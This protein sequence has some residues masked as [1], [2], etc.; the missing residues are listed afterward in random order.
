MATAYEV[1][2]IFNVE[3]NAVSVLNELADLADELVTV[4]GE[5]R[6]AFLALNSINLDPAIASITAL[7][8][9][10]TDTAS[11]LTTLGFMADGEFGNITTAVDATTASVDRLAAS[12][13]AVKGSMAGGAGGRGGAA[14]T[15][16]LGGAVGGLA[17][18]VPP[19][20]LAAAGTYEALHQNWNENLAIRQ[21]LINEGIDPDS[22]Q[23]VAAA[24]SLRT[25][26]QS[27]ATGTIISAEQTSELYKTAA[28]VLGF[29]GPQGLAELSN[30]MPTIVRAA[31]NAVQQ[32]GGS[33]P[34]IVKAD[35]ELAHQLHVYD[36]ERLA[37]VLSRIG[38][39][40]SSTGATLPEELNIL[41]YALPTVGALGGSAQEAIADVGFLQTQMGSTTTAGTSFNR[42]LVSLLY[43]QGPLSSNLLDERGE[44][45]RSIGFSDADR[46]NA[47]SSQ[48]QT[49]LRELGL[50]N[51]FDPH[52]NIDISSVV[53]DLA[54]ARQH[55]TAQQFGT[56]SEQAFGVYGSKAADLLSDPAAQDAEQR[57]ISYVNQQTQRFPSTTEQELI[58]QTDAQLFQQAVHRFMDALNNIASVFEP[59]THISL[60]GLVDGLNW[61]NE[62]FGT[63]GTHGTSGVAAAAADA[64][65]RRQD[66]QLHPGLSWWQEF[67]HGTPGAPSRFPGAAVKQEAYITGESSGVTIHMNGLNIYGAGFSPQEYAQ[68]L[69]EELASQMNKVQINNLGTGQGTYSSKYASGG[70]MFI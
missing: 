67:L 38:W 4:L 3:G 32:T 13:E 43:G 40:A 47:R 24:Q 45:E 52:G 59:L 5:V 6:E 9:Q 68:M 12:L 27:A 2:S 11:S 60:I 15:G 51:I 18:L 1:V 50:T 46:H 62:I 34:D 19:E 53:S 64:A 22:P 7:D 14:D 49:A 69:A 31:E 57:Y 33:L 66:E 25:G 17:R 29:Q 63:P 48:H 30:I 10:L 8:E 65:K 42:M 41:K 56:L 28:G 61:F 36:P 58:S 37:P 35:I 16:F 26:V 21:T 70:N 39:V 20:L 55:M 54:T 44:L 23:G